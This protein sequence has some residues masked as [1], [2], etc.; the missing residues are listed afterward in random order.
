MIATLP[1]VLASSLI[2]HMKHIGPVSIIANVSTF[3]ALALIL[4]SSFT[5]LPSITERKMIGTWD[6]LPLSFGTTIFAMEGIAV[7]IIFLLKFFHNL[8]NNNCNEDIIDL[9]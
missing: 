4:Y 3:A 7:V 9:Q 8:I 2:R 5:D 6:R 1:I